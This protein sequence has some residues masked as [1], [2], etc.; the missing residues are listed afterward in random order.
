MLA[1]QALQ[2]ILQPNQ[3]THEQK[4]CKEITEAYN[5]NPK[6]AYLKGI[7]KAGAVLGAEDYRQPQIQRGSIRG[8]LKASVCDTVSAE[9]AVTCSSRGEVRR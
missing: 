8:E 4:A 5:P 1:R 9:R 7:D 3:T 2:L 6:P